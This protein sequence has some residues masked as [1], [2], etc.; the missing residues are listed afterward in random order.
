M[1][2]NSIV[3]D[4]SI[5]IFR[6][7]LSGIFIVAGISHLL[8]PEKVAGRITGAKNGG[9][10]ILFGDPFLLGLLSGYALLIFGV[11]FMLGIMPRWSAIVLAILLVPI[12][13]TIQ[14][15]NGIMHG[16]L[17]KNIAIFG[18]LLF[19]IINNPQNHTLINIKKIKS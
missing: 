18:G 16:P 8:H 9:F 17:W 14:M 12:T 6:I 1:K 5:L 2:N 4:I 10:A 3:S 13:I 19:F 7:M 15:G 11:T